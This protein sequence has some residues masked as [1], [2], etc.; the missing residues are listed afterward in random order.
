MRPEDE[1][2]AA[3][4][5][6]SPPVDQI[7]DFEGEVSIRETES[8][9]AG[10]DNG[11]EGYERRAGEGRAASAGWSQQVEH[12][13]NG[14]GDAGILECK[15]GQAEDSAEFEDCERRTGRKPDPESSPSKEGCGKLETRLCPIK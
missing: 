12:I 13:G 11:L 14:D 6:C 15:S 3:F 10:V 1:D 7:S 5:R 2:R 9:Q 8:R 4:D